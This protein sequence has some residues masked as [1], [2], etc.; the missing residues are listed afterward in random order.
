MRRSA[1]IETTV[2]QCGNLVLERRRRVAMKEPSRRR[3]VR[4]N[5]TE[6]VR[7]GDEASIAPGSGHRRRCHDRRRRRRLSLMHWRGRRGTRGG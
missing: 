6:L 1:A 4:H 5:T 7:E 3:R 2:V